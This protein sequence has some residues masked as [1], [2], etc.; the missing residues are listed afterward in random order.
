MTGTNK[1][2]SDIRLPEYN[3]AR[4]GRMS[5]T[6]TLTASLKYKDALAATGRYEAAVF[7][8]HGTLASRSQPSP[9]Q[10]SSHAS[11]PAIP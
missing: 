7:M 2:P 6:S 3:R 10:T 1:M 8:E 11:I 9:E 4:S 5:S